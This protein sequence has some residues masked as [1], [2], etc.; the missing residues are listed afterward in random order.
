MSG[1]E[2]HP[3]YG[4]AMGLLSFLTGR[5]PAY[6][7]AATQARVE[8]LK[9]ALPAGADVVAI[10]PSK[11][12]ELT[13]HLDLVTDRATT[14]AILAS[15]VKIVSTDEGRWSVNLSIHD[16]ADESSAFSSVDLPSSRLAV[17][18]DVL[19]AHDEL[20]ALIPTQ[21][22]ML[23]TTDGS[24]T[25]SDVPRD[26][27]VATARAAVTWWAGLLTTTVPP[28]YASNL[29]VDVGGDG[30]N[31]EIT[32]STTIEREPELARDRARGFRQSVSDAEWTAQVFAAWTDNLP[33]L[34]AALRLPV[35]AD[36]SVDLS[37]SASKLKPRLSVT[38]H[39]TFDDDEDA[40]EELVAAIRQQVPDSKL[41]VD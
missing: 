33:V 4:A 30:V 12:M 9:A 17:L 29:S 15:I 34:E 27:A 40:A 6:D 2:P 28:W 38:H 20:H 36:H 1:P 18:D 21:S 41:K 32:Y 7:E 13:Y 11:G 8:A 35:P 24:F 22:I 3:H 16:T 19:R 31:A 5:T 26:Q 25:I 37:F 39:E 23:D 10:P 14:S